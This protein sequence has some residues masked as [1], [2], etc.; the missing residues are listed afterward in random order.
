MLEFFPRLMLW[1]IGSGCHVKALEKGF[2]SQL[3]VQNERLVEARRVFLKTTE[4][5]KTYLYGNNWQWCL[6]RTNIF[7][8]E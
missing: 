4:N 7:R 5:N 6:D 8:P 2:Q 1:N 3:D